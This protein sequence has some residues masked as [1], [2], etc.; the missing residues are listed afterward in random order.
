MTIIDDLYLFQFN[1]STSYEGSDNKINNFQNL[2][3]T[4][5]LKY[6]RETKENL[7]AVW[8]KTRTPPSTTL[9]AI[10]RP[11]VPKDNKSIIEQQHRTLDKLS[12]F[13]SREIK[14]TTEETVNRYYRTLKRYPIARNSKNKIPEIARFF[15]TGGFAF[16]HHIPQLKIPEFIVGV[17]KA[18]FDSSFGED[19]HLLIFIKNEKSSDRIFE[20]AAIIQTNPDIIDY[21]Q[22][23][24][25]N[26]NVESNIRLV[27][28]DKLQIL[29]KG[30]TLLVGW[31]IPI[32]LVPGNHVLPP[33]CI[34]FEGYG[35]IKSGSFT[36]V[37]PSGRKQDSYYNCLEAFVTYF[38]PSMKYSVPGTEGFLDKE[39]LFTSY[40]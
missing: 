35:K 1:S 17:F 9:Q 30:N 2:F 18:N 8:I 28:K 13:K 32:P 38:H 22:K 31:T 24:Y 39:F 14:S 26:T 16:I 7:G 27:G 15:G 40:L 10:I 11:S 4:T 23:A 25:E 36:N 21:R 5:N 12:I 20:P 37:F 29:A 33:S 3:F 34:L 19:N 6:I